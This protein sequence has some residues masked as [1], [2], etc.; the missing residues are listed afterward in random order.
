MPT[1]SRIPPPRA[2]REPAA[3]AEIFRAIADYTYDWE[4]WVD[5]DG[6]TRWI[7]P[8]V[9]RI[10]GFTVAECLAMQDY[11][12][13]L[14]H[15]R[16]R[17]RIRRA[18]RTAHQGGSGN[19]LEFRVQRK[20]G[21]VGWGAISWQSLFDVSGICRGYRTSVR[22]IS[23]RK[24][25]EDEL[26]QAKVTAEQAS[27]AKGEFLANMSHELRSPIQCISGYAELLSKTKLTPKQKRYLAV[28]GQQNEAL[29]KVVD[30][31]LDFSALQAVMPRFEE[32][33]FEVSDV[34]AH[35]V[36]GARPL[37]QAK[38]LTLSAEIAPAA[39]LCVSGD[40]HRL[41]QILANLVSNALK[42]TERG[43]VTLHVARGGP[44]ERRRR[45]GPPL[46]RDCRHRDR[47]L[48]RQLAAPVS[49][50]RAGRYVHGAPLWGHRAGPG[51]QPAALR[52][53]GR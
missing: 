33:P 46:V 45:P 53:H 24:Q 48:T 47:D 42:F 5:V 7:N 51:D 6:T 36:D 13:P 11:P 30:D 23:S 41:R 14:V 25:A 43:S 18:L 31:I 37:A 28:L 2:A 10:T 40:A 39:R 44:E 16:D 29:L 12:L 9:Q 50:L 21:T 1:R 32:L 3:P 22:D 34:V 4:S 17:A 19:D 26:R 49:P 15:R 35:V 8:A 20:D 38:G 52:A 27:R